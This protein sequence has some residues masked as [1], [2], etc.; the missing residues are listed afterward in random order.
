VLLSGREVEFCDFLKVRKI[1]LQEH[2]YL[3]GTG[4]DTMAH[5]EEKQ[6]DPDVPVFQDHIR[7][8]LKKDRAL[9]DLSIKCFVSFVRAYSKH[10]ASYIFRLKD[11]DLLGTA[12]SF[13]LL[14]LPRMPE[15]KSSSRDGW[16]DADILVSVTSIA[17]FHLPDVSTPSGIPLLTRMHHKRRKDSQLQQISDYHKKKRR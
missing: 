13:G 17:P 12:K 7:G 4:N 14:R 10:E 16:Q 9:H 15:L 1:P 2:P 3:K 8:I 5:A 11:L 6:E